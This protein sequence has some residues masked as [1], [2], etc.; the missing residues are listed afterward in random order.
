MPS[1][2]CT[3]QTSVTK[4]AKAVI[5]Q[6]TNVSIAGPSIAT[7]PSRTGSL[8]LAAPCA[9]GAVPIPASLEKA[10]RWAPT[11]MIDPTAPPSTEV[12]VNASVT[13]KLSEGRICSAL[14][15]K[16]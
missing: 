9:M 6:T 5:V 15:N 14:A 3:C 16:I 13:T 7:K 11:I 8:V 4:I 10:A 2:P 1:I 12:A